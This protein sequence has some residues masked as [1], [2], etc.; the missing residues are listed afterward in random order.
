M[1]IA[2]GQPMVAD[3]ILHLTFFPVG[4]ILMY[5]GSGWTDN[6]TLKGWYACT[7]ANAAAGL[8]P[9]LTNKFI[10]GAVTK[11]GGGGSNSLT[12]TTSNL[13]AHSHQL[14]GLSADTASGHTHNYSG[15]SGGG[16]THSHNLSA[17]SVSGGDHS[18]TF[19]GTDASGY[20][21]IGDATVLVSRGGMNGV[22]SSQVGITW[23]LESSSNS[24]GIKFSMT[25]SGTIGSTG[26]THTLA[27]DTAGEGSHIHS[28]SGTTGG[29]G[30][31]THNISGGSVGDTGSGMAFDNRPSYYALIYIRK[32]A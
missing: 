7:A 32:C 18:H 22:F 4:A 9:D 12:L 15:S 21:P 25:P 14:S 19:T 27:G 5:D 24:S 1:T 20:I 16:T 11:G 8:T 26:H 23:G 31:H 13:P 3:D 6:V 17:V 29:D 28:F 10:M 30:A 2:K